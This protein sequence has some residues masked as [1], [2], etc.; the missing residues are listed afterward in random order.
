[1]NVE[2][3]LYELLSASNGLRET[4]YWHKRSRGER[5]KRLEQELNAAKVRLLK[6][7]NAAL[8]YKR[9]AEEKDRDNVGTP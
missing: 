6:A 1:M 9:A 4:M 3:I 8:D 7:E 5:R 2:A